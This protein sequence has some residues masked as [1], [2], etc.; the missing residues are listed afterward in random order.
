MIDPDG[1]TTEEKLHAAAPGKYTIDL[2]TSQ[3]GLYHFNIRRMEDGQIQN[4]MTTAAA[5]QFSDEYKIH[6]TTDS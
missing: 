1:N 6:V 5:V 3:A 2:P 4:Y